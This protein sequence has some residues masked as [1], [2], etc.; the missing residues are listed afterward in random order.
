V[1][2]RTFLFG[3]KAA[4]GYLMAK[5]IIKLVNSVGEVV[6]NDPDVR[7]R[8]RVVFLPDYNVTLGQRVYPA[9]DLS[10]QI[11]LAGKE[12]SGTGNMK[13]AMNG[14]LTV[15]TLDGANIE[16]R[17]AVGAENFFLFGL[18]TDQVYAK[19]AAGYDLE[20]YYNSNLELK[21]ALNGLASGQFSRGD[22]GL[23][24]PL[25]D[26][27]HRFD[28]Y[29]LL[30]DYQSYI[31]CQDKISQAYLDRD[32]WTRMSILNTARMGKFSSDRA[33]REYCDEIWSAKP[34]K[35]ELADLSPEA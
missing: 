17:D 22:A 5:L 10:E 34:V 24:R 14:A 25:L 19:K 28:P 4:P 3:G 15:G 7:G 35:V 26:S 6:N 9:A 12:A 2:P 30:A 20:H 8:L 29:M 13:F 21:E 11:S 1:V 23:F 16:I 18:T 32:Q 31:E 27:L 33:I